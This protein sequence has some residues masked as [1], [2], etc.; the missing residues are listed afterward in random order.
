MKSVTPISATFAY[1]S[2]LDSTALHQAILAQGAGNVIVD[3]TKQ[4][5]QI[6][7]VGVALHPASNSPVTIVFKGTSGSD[8]LVITPGQVVH[9]DPFVGFDWGLPFGWLG[10][11]PVLLYVMHSKEAQINFAGSNAPVPFHRLRVPITNFNADPAAPGTPNWPLGFPWANAFRLSG[12]QTIPQQAR[13]VLQVI[14][15]ITLMQY[16][17]ACSAPIEL[18]AKWINVDPF[19]LNS[20]PDQATGYDNGVHYYPV[21]ISSANQ[22]GGGPNLAA[23]LWLPPE[24]GQLG[25]DNAA[26]YLLD[27]TNTLGGTGVYVDVVRYGRFM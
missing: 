5:A 13:P 21:T 1:Q 3:S 11:G 26:F 10:G 6:P 14:P 20:P 9:V 15:D 22:T 17:G 12:T 25:G 19:D 8:P 4:T 18:I 2:Y 27:P 7:G 23:P 16:T 24:I